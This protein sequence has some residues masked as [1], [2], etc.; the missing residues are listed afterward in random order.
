MKPK[1][2]EAQEELKTKKLRD[3]ARY[4]FIEKSSEK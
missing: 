2:V 4:N 1:E 3:K